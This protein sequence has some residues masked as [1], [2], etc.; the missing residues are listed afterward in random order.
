[1]STTLVGERQTRD[2]RPSRRRAETRA[3]RGLVV[4]TLVVLAVQGWFGDFV[5]VFVTPANGISQPPLTVAGL[6][7]E[8]QLLPTPFFPIWH[9]V[10]GLVLVVLAIAIL[11]LSLG[12]PHSRGVRVWSGLGLL[13]VL[14]A[15]LGGLLFVKSGYA[16]GGNSMQMGGSF[17]AAFASYFLVLYYTK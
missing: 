8:L 11:V 13:S 16:D 4:A 3:L 7:H 9:A 12:W 15:A 14:S 1:M 17:I 6:L 5:T 10:E 2:A